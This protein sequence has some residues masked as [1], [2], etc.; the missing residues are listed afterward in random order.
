V[1]GRPLSPA[2]LKAYLLEQHSLRRSTRTLQQY[3]REGGGP[4]YVRSGNDVRYYTDS[5]D[6][7]V[8]DLFGEEVTSTSEES[9][10]RLLTVAKQEG[11]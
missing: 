11:S 5:V 6:A 7:W 4:P 8:A 10:R 9:A 3:R 2:E 1:Q